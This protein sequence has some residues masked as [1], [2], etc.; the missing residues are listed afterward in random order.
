MKREEVLSEVLSPMESTVV[1]EN[2][3]S[4]MFSEWR[5]Q[6]QNE[7]VQRVVV[8]SS[9]QNRDFRTNHG[10]SVI[11]PEA[12]EG[13][14][15]AQISIYRA[16]LCKVVQLQIILFIGA[17]LLSAPLAPTKESD[18]GWI[19]V[20]AL[21]GSY[22]LA[23]VIYH[24]IVM[25]LYKKADTQVIALV[26]SYKAQF[27]DSFGVEIGHRP[28]TKSVRWWK[29]DSGIYLRRPRRQPP[30]SAAAV[31][32]QAATIGSS[33]LEEILDYTTSSSIPP[34]FIGL[35]IPGDIHMNEQHYDASM[36]VDA[37]AWKLLQETH[38]KMI[39]LSPAARVFF[40]TYFSVLLIF[41]FF[42]VVSSFFWMEHSFRFVL[43]VILLVLILGLFV[44][45]RVTDRRNLQMYQEVS[46]RV[47][48]ALQKGDGSAD[49][50]V[51]FTSS[52]LPGRLPVNFRRYQFA[53]T[54]AT[55]GTPTM[56]EI[57]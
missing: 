29:E 12:Y 25:L 52:E 50:V 34:I 55:T 32:G 18:P 47:T 28:S 43:M 17:I 56:A 14:R 2:F 35:V 4:E 9:F 30:T 39:P 5:L 19:F 44:V 15:R 33:E 7:G 40:L 41:F 36:K 16:L 11:D 26:E 21:T 57:V 27:L 31:E 42:L 20:A 22:L 51:E 37:T 24:Y 45:L 38:R 8:N 1:V 6:F 48:E 46:Q 23:F 3:N 53:R 49:L 54:L 10:T 13:L